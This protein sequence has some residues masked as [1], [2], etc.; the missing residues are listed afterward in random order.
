[1]Y[2][3]IDIC[4]LHRGGVS[5]DAVVRPTQDLV[6]ISATLRQKLIVT[7]TKIYDPTHSTSTF[8]STSQESLAF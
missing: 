1:M 5:E 7:A 8:L 2:V 6:R 3:R 4:L